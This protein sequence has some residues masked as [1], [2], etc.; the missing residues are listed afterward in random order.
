MY[1]RS[2]VASVA[3]L[4]RSS[5]HDAPFQASG[6]PTSSSRTASFSLSALSPVREQAPL[7]PLVGMASSF[8]SSPGDP[9][10]DALGSSVAALKVAISEPNI[11]HDISTALGPSLSSASSLHS[12]ASLLPTSSHQS[13]PAF[14]AN[15]TP[16]KSKSSAS[17]IPREDEEPESP[18]A[19]ARRSARRSSMFMQRSSE[20]YTFCARVPKGLSTEMVTVYVKRGCRLAVV[21]DAWHLEHD[22]TSARWGSAIVAFSLPAQRIANGRLGS[23]LGT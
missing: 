11:G 13:E 3:S 20:Q 7:L 1:C 14:E 22:G 4:S 23:L 12:L 18:I 16:L 19:H 2:A 6:L 8:S 10:V 15:H 5:G 9:D 21:A 17:F